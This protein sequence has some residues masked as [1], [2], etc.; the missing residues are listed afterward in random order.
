[1]K[2]STAPKKSKPT[3]GTTG[4][5]SAHNKEADLPIDV[6]P[7]EIFKIVGMGDLFR[8]WDCRISFPMNSDLFQFASIANWN[9]CYSVARATA[10]RTM[11]RRDELR[12][13]LGS[14]EL[15]RRGK[16]EK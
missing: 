14:N 10:C 16:N 11:S 4:N 9:S 15:R 13:E 7:E 8:D 3:F 2:S 1:M 12:R 5:Q 6:V